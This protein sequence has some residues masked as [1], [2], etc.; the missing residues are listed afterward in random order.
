MAA[1]ERMALRE[2][3]NTYNMDNPTRWVGVRRIRSLANLLPEE[4]HVAA[5]KNFFVESMRQLR[6]EL[7][8][9][10][11]ERPDLPWAGEA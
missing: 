4:D 1:M 10:K 8:A 7:T 9:F 2:D 5:V 3:W 6:A 11:K